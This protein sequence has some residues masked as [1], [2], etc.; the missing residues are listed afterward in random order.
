M[1][2]CG[3]FE[4]MGAKNPLDFSSSFALTLSRPSR[5]KTRKK[6]FMPANTACYLLKITR[7]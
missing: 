5:K 2:P 1:P 7:T 6:K 3:M 4:Q